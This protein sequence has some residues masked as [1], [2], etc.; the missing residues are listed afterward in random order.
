MRCSGQRLE[1]SYPSF[2]GTAAS[3]TLATIAPPNIRSK[4]SN[5]Q[6][7]SRILRMPPVAV[8]G[9]IYPRGAVVSAPTS[10]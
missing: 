6:Y 3:F 5:S 8:L 7:V 10:R 9:E 1:S 4:P 2:S